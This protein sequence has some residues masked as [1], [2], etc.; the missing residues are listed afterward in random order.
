[1][2]NLPILNNELFININNNPDFYNLIVETLPYLKVKLDQNATYPNKHHWLDLRNGIPKYFA[3]DLK[4]KTFSWADN[5]NSQNVDEYPYIEIVDIAHLS[6]LMDQIYDRMNR[7]IQ[8][9]RP[10]YE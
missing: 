10:M 6:S 4:Y 5:D 2:N 8:S 1:M 7:S 9:Y 3:F